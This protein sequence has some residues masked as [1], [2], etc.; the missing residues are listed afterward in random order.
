MNASYYE[1]S[2]P[3]RANDDVRAAGP[4][5][6]A[7]VRASL[8]AALSSRSRTAKAA[9]FSVLV[10]VL[11]VPGGSASAAPGC[12]SRVLNIVAHEDDDLLFLNPDVRADLVAGKCVRTVFVN[13]GDNADP[14][15][16]AYWMTREG[17]PRAA[18]AQMRGVANNWTVSDLGIPNHPVQLHTLNGDPN[19]S[20][21]FMRLPDGFVDGRFPSAL[22][23]LYRDELASTAALD[24]T[25]SYTRAG[26]IEALASIM[27]GF[28]PD[29][30]RT[31]D[32]SLPL[33]YVNGPQADHM[34][35]VAVAYFVKDANERYQTPHTLSGYIDYSIS[36]L[37]A[38]LT[39]TETT[40]KTATFETY[41]PFDD[42]LCSNPSTSPSCGIAPWLSRRYTL[43]PILTP[44][45]SRFTPLAPA[46]VLDTRTGNG[47]PATKLTGGQVLQLQITGRG[48]VPA[49]AT[50]AVINITVTEP[51]DNGHITA[52]PCDLPTPTA[53]N[54]NFRVGQTIA[55][56][57]NV[58]L[59]AAGKVCLFSLA[60]THLVADVGGYFSPSGSLFTPV[61][62]A[63]VLDTRTG[64]GA[65]ATKLTGGQ[66]LQLQ[67]TGRGGVPAGATAAVINITVTEPDDNGH[68]TAYPCDLPTPT[69]SNLNFRVGQTIANLAN[70]RLDA[71][72]KVCLFSLAPTHLVADVGGYFL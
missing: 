59:D 44:T 25:S 41:A 5:F 72:G 43:A 49:G 58:R 18:Y 8:P 42:L 10:A 69:A 56:L 15:G 66:V 14:R 46:R 20:L 48:G 64:N 37:P 3:S 38:N 29:V 28:S 24:S 31:Q 19:V 39:Q 13:A 54:L 60:P 61:A 55:N 65:P 4:S 47:A 6:A 1:A 7:R 30:I 35:H 34:D 50:A 70:V 16:A 11:W 40:Q 32:W 52:Y 36:N 57:A 12:A 71:A 53:S 9:I 68:I 67:I 62:P 22:V 45:R 27:N 26:L 63:R 2:A 33:Q 21:A 17:G 23:K 51:D